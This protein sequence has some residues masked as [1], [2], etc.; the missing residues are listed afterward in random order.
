MYH[1]NNIYLY[2][3]IAIIGCVCL[4]GVKFQNKNFLLLYNLQYIIY[5]AI[6]CSLNLCP[7]IN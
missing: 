6:F 2:M 5:L 3:N 1:F 7:F 4:K